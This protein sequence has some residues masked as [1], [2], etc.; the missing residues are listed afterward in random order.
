MNKFKLIVLPLVF[1]AS[2]A[3]AQNAPDTGISESTDP[4]K[5]AEVERRAQDLRSQGSS[6]SGGA[7]GSGSGSGASSMDDQRRG[8][9]ARHGARAQHGGQH[10]SHGARGHDQTGMQPSQK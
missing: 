9:K 6:M 7:S 8:M 3:I 10:G 5:V 4:G 2:A 1:S